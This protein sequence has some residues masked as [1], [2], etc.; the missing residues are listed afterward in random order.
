MAVA[1]TAA[2]KAVLEFLA[3]M[4][5]IGNFLF[6]I[7]TTQLW[8]MIEGMQIIVMYPMLMIDAPANLALVQAA[9]RKISTFEIID[10]DILKEQLW[11]YEDEEDLGD[12]GYYF[13]S[14]GLDSR[15]FMFTFGLPLYVLAYTVV[16]ALALPA[17][18]Y[19]R[20]TKDACRVA[21]D[22][23]GGDDEEKPEKP[24]LVGTKFMIGKVLQ[25]EKGLIQKYC[26]T[27]GT[28]N[29]LFWSFFVAFYYE[30][31]MEICISIFSAKDHLL[32]P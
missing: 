12:D 16:M 4:G 15:F 23:E 27:K 25:F 18:N 13:I 32:A 11:Q 2:A 22:F 17:I 1:A 30:S 14:A 21:D 9:L 3:S 31:T 26:D 28:Q 8:S 10:G 24:P 19:I 29:S 6:G 5:P 20:Y 7:S